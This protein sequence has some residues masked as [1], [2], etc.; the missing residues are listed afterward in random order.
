MQANQDTI[1]LYAYFMRINDYV[2]EIQPFEKLKVR[3]INDKE[4]TSQVPKLHESIK[5]PRLN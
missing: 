2:A 1:P 5:K 4:P 3:K